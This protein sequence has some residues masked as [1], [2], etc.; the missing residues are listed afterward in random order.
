MGTVIALLC[1]SVSF[2]AIV[3]CIL[4]FSARKSIRDASIQFKR[5]ISMSNTN[6]QL[7][8]S[9]PNK[10][11]ESLLIQINQLLAEKQ[12]ERIRF[13][14]KERELRNQIE[15]ISHDLRTPLTSILGYLDLVLDCADS[16]EYLNIIEKRARTLQTLVSSFYDLS[17]L[18]ANDYVLELEVVESGNILCETMISF[19][20]QFE[21]KNIAVELDVD[22][23]FMYVDPSA[24]ARVFSNLAQNALIHGDIRLD[25]SHHKNDKYVEI[26]FSN[27]AK[28]LTSENAL[29]VFERSF[30]GGNSRSGTGLGLA[31]SK[32]LVKRMGGN[33]YSNL[34]EDIF[35]ITILFPKVA[36]L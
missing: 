18:D 10:E 14:N 9:S 23:A 32:A 16:G 6:E 11:L 22:E 2:V 24:L 13:E 31:I 25:V 21:N 12:S 27:H 19:Y 33:I 28:D 30:T 8:C 4:Y 26:R 7:L 3:F 29:R 20:E 15:N 1:V 34:D 17:R 5:I 36:K 35:S